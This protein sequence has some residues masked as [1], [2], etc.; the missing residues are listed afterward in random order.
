MSAPVHPRCK[1]GVAVAALG[2]DVRGL[3]RM[4]GEIGLDQILRRVVTILRGGLPI[5]LSLRTFNAIR[6]VD[7]SK[8]L[9]S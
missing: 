5:H 2:V 1:V 6:L 9:R 8:Q 7:D 4:C 3:L